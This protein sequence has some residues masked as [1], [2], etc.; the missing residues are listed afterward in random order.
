MAYTWVERGFCGPNPLPN[1]GMGIGYQTSFTVAA[2]G[3][4]IVKLPAGWEIAIFVFPTSG[5]TGKI[6]GTGVKDDDVDTT[7]RW[8]E[9]E[10]FTADGNTYFDS[11]ATALK[12]TAT[13]Q[14]CI[15]DLVLIRT[16]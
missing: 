8:I 6:Y 3:N 9:L 4:E 11:E 10:S 7:T 1:M 12:F 16:R 14:S 15:F 2:D 5:G 13:T